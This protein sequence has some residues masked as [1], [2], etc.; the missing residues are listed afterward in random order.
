MP[1][2]AR[3]VFRSPAALPCPCTGPSLSRI[4]TTPWEVADRVDGPYVA[5]ARNPPPQERRRAIRRGRPLHRPQ[6]VAAADAL[7]R[8]RHVGDEN[9]RGRTRIQRPD[10]DS[11]PA[12]S[13]S[14]APAMVHRRISSLRGVAIL[15]PQH[16]PNP[17]APAHQTRS[18]HLKPAVR[19]SACRAMHKPGSGLAG[20]RA[21]GLCLCRGRAPGNGVELPRLVLGRR[22]RHPSGD[23]RSSRIAVAGRRSP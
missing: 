9:A 16:R 1:A 4:T 18:G 6:V 20:P 8:L 12:W 5:A 11:S 22:L 2:G 13:A 21:V 17:R 19:S 14:R 3:L 23:A 15:R 7:A 10:R